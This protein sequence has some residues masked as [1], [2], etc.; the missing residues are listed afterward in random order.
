MVTLQEAFPD[1][2]EFTEES[3]SDKALSNLS[4]WIKKIRSNMDGMSPEG[5]EQTNTYIKNLV[6]SMGELADSSDDVKGLFMDMF[7]PENINNPEAQ[8]E[9]GRMSAQFDE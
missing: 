7:A 5:I 2:K 6:E 8:K 3:I 9:R 1:L 4:E